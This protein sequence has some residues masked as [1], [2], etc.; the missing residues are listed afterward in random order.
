[1]ATDWFRRTTWTPADATEFAE[2]LRR[3]RPHSRAQY[4]RI[5]AGHLAEASPPQFGPALD[6]L[7]RVIEEYP[8]ELHLAQAHFQRAECLLA[9]GRADDA[10]A[11]FLEA[12]S[13][14]RRFPNARTPAY[15]KFAY[16]VAATGRTSLFDEALELLEEFANG[17]VFP[18]QVYLHNAALALIAASNGDTV[19]AQAA[20]RR[21][22]GAAQ[23]SHSGFRYH[24]TVGLVTDVDESVVKHL[25]DLA[26]G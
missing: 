15:L 25:S 11:A 13:T 3:T 10:V 18:A 22:L 4:L 5:Q 9:L 21:A 7:D 19:V 1:M 23:Q 12:V 20:A 6:L 24:P 8:D 26:A 17:E 2:R 14:E 16:W